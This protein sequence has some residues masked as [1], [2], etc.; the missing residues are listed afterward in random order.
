M[1]TLMRFEG[2]VRP[3][4]DEGTIAGAAPDRAES[5]DGAARAPATTHAESFRNV[6][7]LILICPSLS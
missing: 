3:N 7:L 4:T 1:A 6:R 5:F 2:D